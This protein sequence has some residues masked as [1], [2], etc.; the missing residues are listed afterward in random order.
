M[1]IST[2][3]TKLETLCNEKGLGRSAKSKINAIT[4]KLNELAPLDLPG[5]ASNKSFLNDYLSV[6]KK[7]TIALVLAQKTLTQ[8]DSVIFKTTWN[9]TNIE[10][11]NTKL[12]LARPKP[13]KPT[14]SIRKITPP[15]HSTN[16]P[17]KSRRININKPGLH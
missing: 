5:S 4:K 6:L 1:N 14:A 13:I 8:K 10:H 15:G 9:L 17:A 3:I 11:T 12:Q 16:A 2:L 7:L